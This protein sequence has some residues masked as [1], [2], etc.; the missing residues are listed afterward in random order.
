[1]KRYLYETYQ[2]PLHK[3]NVISYGES[4]PVAPNN[5]RETDARRIAESSSSARVDRLVRTIASAFSP[6]HQ[7]HG[8]ALKADAIGRAHL[9][10][11][12]VASHADAPR[13]VEGD[14]AADA[15]A[16]VVV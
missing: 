3:I 2:I 16:D 10:V 8:E 4:K 1:M 5:T 7:P 6:Q 13:E 9:E 12:Q 15:V 14:P 11:P